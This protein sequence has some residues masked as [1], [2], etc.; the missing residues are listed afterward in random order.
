MRG[1]HPGADLGPRDVVARAIAARAAADGA[2]VTLDLRH[3]D[4]ERVRARFPTVAALCRDHGLDLA[5]DPIPVT[6][7]AHYAMGGVLTDLQGPLHRARPVGRRGVRLDRRPRRQP[8]GL[9]QPARG[10]RL[11]RPGGPR[12]GPGRRLAGRP[13]V[14]PGRRSPG[15]AA[16]GG[17]ARAALARAMWDG[18]GVERDAAGLAAAR[19]ALDAL[20]DA[21]DPETANLLLVARLSARAAELRTESRGAHFRR[22]HPATGPRPAARI[23]WAGGE[24][25]EIPLDPPT[26]R[27]EREAA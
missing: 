5:R 12:P 10:R 1:L 15:A 17:A 2:D 6:P 9:Q 16:D 3:L 7:A 14:R 23:A 8:P 11:R 21:A 4:P 13:P 20:P 19:R 24:P 25:R 18:V 26:V 27:H 22:D